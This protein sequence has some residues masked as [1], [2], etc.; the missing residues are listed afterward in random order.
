[1]RRGSCIVTVQQAA[2]AA[3]TEMENKKRIFETIIIRSDPHTPKAVSMFAKRN[4]NKIAT[5]KKSNE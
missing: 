2:V 3:A 5:T 4:N 1:M